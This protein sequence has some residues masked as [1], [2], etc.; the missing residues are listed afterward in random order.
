MAVQTGLLASTRLAEARKI[1]AKE[2]NQA[3]AIY[4]EI[5][6]HSPTDKSQADKDAAT[7]VDYENALL[8]LGELYRDTERAQELAELVRSSTSRLAIFTKA[9]TAKL[10]R[11]PSSYHSGHLDEREDGVQ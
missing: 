3:E 9:K 6:S 5:L 8:G 4:R 2:P 10:G 7:L 11:S 1:A